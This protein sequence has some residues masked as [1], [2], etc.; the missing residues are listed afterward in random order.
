MYGIYTLGQHYM[1]YERFAKASGMGGL[2]VSFFN[3]IQELHCAIIKISI[4]FKKYFNTLHM[5]CSHS[6]SEDY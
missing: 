2:P 6:K 4:L 3:E 5:M 1:Q